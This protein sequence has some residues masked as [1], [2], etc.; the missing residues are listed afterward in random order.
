MCNESLLQWMRRTGR[1]KPPGGTPQGTREPR[2]A[3]GSSSRMPAATPRDE[4]NLPDC[5]DCLLLTEC[6]IL[7]TQLDLR[8]IDVCPAAACVCSPGGEPD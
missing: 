1:L 7:C 3:P 8:Q 4:R 5:K 6:A 2:E